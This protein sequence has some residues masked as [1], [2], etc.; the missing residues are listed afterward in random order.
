MSSTRAAHAWFNSSASIPQFD[1]GVALPTAS[2]S[3]PLESGSA[4]RARSWRA[5]AAGALEGAAFTI[6]LSLGSA[7]LVFSHIGPG[8]LAAGVLATLLAMAFVHAATLRSRRPLLYSARFFEATTTTAMLDQMV[9][10]MPAWSLHD[11]PAVR[12]ALLC[13]VMAGAGLW[14]GVLFLLRADRFARFVPA[15]VFAGFSNGIAVVILVSQVRTFG[16]MFDGMR[17]A[18]VIAIGAATIAA[19]V[20]VRHRLPRWPAAATALGVGIALGLAWEGTGYVVP[21]LG[22]VS[23]DMH[24]PVLAADFRAL[25]AAGVAH[26]ALA[27]MV[28]ANAMILGSMIFL[29]TT[30]AAQSL[31][32]SDDR[33]RESSARLAWTALCLAAAGAAG[34]APLSGTVQASTAASRHHPLGAGTLAFTAAILGAVAA[35]GVV[36]WIPIAAVAGTLASEAWFMVDRPSL[37]NLL[38]WLRGHAPGKHAREDLALIAAVTATAVMMN[39]V[40]A[41]IAGLMLGLLLFAIRNARRPVRRSWTGLQ[42]SSNCA[43]ARADLRTLGQHGSR[44]RVVEFERDLFFGAVDSLERALQAQLHEAECIVLDWSAVR[45]VDSTAARCVAKFERLATARAVAV[46]HV[47]PEAGTEVD[48]VLAQYLPDRR[49]AA[50][51]DRALELA[52]NHLLARHAAQATAEASTLLE[53][54]SLL[55]GLDEAQRVRLQEAMEQRMLRRGE[56]LVTAG[57]FSSELLMVL[58]GS[59]S[60]LLPRT[61]GDLRVAGVRRGAT[62]GEMGFL[63]G[64]ARSA[65][66]IAEEDTLVAVLTR[67]A[68][69]RLSEEDPALGRRVLANIAIDMAARLRHSNLVASARHRR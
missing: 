8:A 50:D 4:S 1:P 15:P 28:A 51:L 35:S 36:A 39:M 11:S 10:L 31:S 42:L 67:E 40:A 27:W 59:A 52:E 56:A 38:A 55:Q 37:R 18:G 66:V 21:M 60:V 12:L 17:M 16:A 57:E 61:G 68:F 63:D 53:A 14:F 6:P 49:G 7:T 45:D 34:S 43:R 30:I 24:L 48:S 26:G 62:V 13:C 2:S 69:D 22:A 41:V 29:N 20:L 47:D 65:S 64:A 19:N 9:R 5:S 44:I 23:H 32:Q 58:Q 46:F 33:P 54:A 25:G 3:S